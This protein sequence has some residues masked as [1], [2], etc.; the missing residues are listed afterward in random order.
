MQ[1]SIEYK[2]KVGQKPFYYDSTTGSFNKGTIL[3]VEIESYVSNATL[4]NNIIY[5]VL[6]QNGTTA[7]FPE[8]ALMYT[9]V[10]GTPPISYTLTERFSPLDDAWTISDVDNGIFNVKIVS[11]VA[12]IYSTYTV[13]EYSV[14]FSQHECSIKSNK[15]N[16]VNLYETYMDALTALGIV[17]PSNTPTPTY[18]PTPSP[19][20][21][22]SFTPTP[23]PTVS[24]T[25][26]L[27]PT[28]SVTPSYTPSETVTPTPTPEP[29]YS[30]TPTPTITVSPS[31]PAPVTY[32]I[33]SKLNSTG[34]T[35]VK[36]TPVSL[37]L[38]G[39]LIKASSTDTR[40]RSY[41]GL[42]LD[43]YIDDSTYGRI[44]MEG[45]INNSVINWNDI[46][47]EGSSLHQGNNYYLAEEGTI[48]IF[49]PTVGY[50]KIIGYAVTNDTF[51]LRDGTVIKI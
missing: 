6:R 8:N 49:P 18:T 46:I 19:T 10:G 51:D 42:V 1:N 23:T 26:T 7:Q 32:S 13:I 11:T 20:V 29:S 47:K 24:Y 41:L 43:D 16:E 36:G 28:M 38:D 44:L 9:S 33:T 21:S 35:L 27:T 25:P 14:N 50:V 37:A 40:A 30:P 34:L 39:T 4:V 48:S 15:I 22:A 45:T 17:L 5:T 3:Q 12:R 2:F 31:V